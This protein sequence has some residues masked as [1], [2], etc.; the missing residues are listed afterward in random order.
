MFHTK[1]SLLLATM[2]LPLT[3]AAQSGNFV[4]KADYR[5]VS[6][7]YN[8]TDGSNNPALLGRLVYKSLA[9]VNIG[10][11]HKSGSLHDVDDGKVINGLDVGFYGIQKVGKLSF[12]GLFVYD[13]SRLCNRNWNSTLYVSPENPY[14]IGDTYEG[15]FTN[16]TFHLNGGFAYDISPVWSA[17]LRAD[18]KAGS[19]A[20]QTDPRPD[21]DGIRFNIN[22]GATYKFNDFTFGL[23]G[24]YERLSESSEYT[25]VRTTINY[26]VS[27]MQGLMEPVSRQAIGHDR[28][29]TGNLF[30][31]NLQF[32]WNTD[33]FENFLDL[34]ITHNQEKA[35]DGSTSS[36]Y[37]GGKYVSNKYSVSDRFK[38]YRDKM[39][40]QAF[41]SADYSKI[42]GTT[43]DQQQTSD[44][45]GNERWDLLGSSIT[46]KNKI[47]N[48]ELGCSADVM[49][50]DSTPKIS[51]QVK[52]GMHSEQEKEFPDEYQQ[53]YTIGYLDLDAKYHFN[54]RKVFLTANA[55]ARFNTRMSNSQDLQGTI[56]D[57]SYLVPK[58]EYA[59]AKFFRV[60]ARMEAQMPLTINTLRTWV[61]VYAA[62]SYTKYNGD[63]ALLKDSKRHT[64][65][66][67][68]SMCF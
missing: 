18:F 48:A 33:A 62:Y 29:Y 20:D 42:D 59:S 38:I 13:N 65:D 26:P 44:A 57:N 45:N 41:A 8:I 67:G 52:V 24:Q 49:T 58:Y 28:K 14:K 35:E 50:E 53:K 54:V 60:R 40:Y 15:N 34:G 51:G 37:R 25:V 30:G 2:L 64:V 43:Y 19:S 66:L 39:V 46:Y 12:E 61:G 9:D 3:A 63:Y 7:I 17:G 22:P 6:K 68:V 31:G 23:S 55:G 11:A 36:K 56:Y 27:L 16:E 47:V 21:I 1:T 32:G 4:Q 5:D 10:Y